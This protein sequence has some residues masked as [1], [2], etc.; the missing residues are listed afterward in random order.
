LP[1]RQASKSDFVSNF[2]TITNCNVAQN[3]NIR[4]TTFQEEVLAENTFLS[5]PLI[6]PR[7]YSL[8]IASNYFGD[9]F[10][11]HDK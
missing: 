3:S 11:E 9:Y 2:S 5:T 10:F 1:L 6:L 7:G 8:F 4:K